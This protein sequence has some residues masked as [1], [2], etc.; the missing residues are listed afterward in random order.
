L[1]LATNVKSRARAIGLT[2]FEV[3]GTK[4]IDE[5]ASLVAEHFR[6]EPT[7]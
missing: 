3:D 5:I 7:P 6:L 1:R 2:V 4:S